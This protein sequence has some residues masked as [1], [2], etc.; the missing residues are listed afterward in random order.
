M[1][2]DRLLREVE[3]RL[4]DQPESLRLEILDAL[5]EE[6]GRERRHYPVESSVEIER[7][8][9]AEA[10][11]LR[12]VLEAINRQARLEETIDEVLKQLRRLVVYDSCSVALVG[13]GEGFRIIAV[14][15]FAEPEQ[16]IGRR[17]DSLLSR[18]MRAWPRPIS[19]ADV[20]EDPRCADVPGTG[21]IRS[22]A[23][24][25]LLVEGEIIGMLTLDR[26]TVNP[27]DEEDVHRAKAVAFSAAAAIRKAQLHEQLKRYASLMERVVA[28]DHA[29]FTGRPAADV[30]RVILE[31]ALRIGSHR[32][33]LLIIK[34]AGVDTV[35]AATGPFAPLQ[36]QAPP[37]AFIVAGATR[38]SASQ[39]AKLGRS[40]DLT[41]PDYGMYVVPLMVPDAVVGSLALLDPDGETPDDRLME[42]YASRAATA[43]LHATRK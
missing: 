16:M 36:G 37:A 13:P 30:A 29:V 25:P 22:W 7:E 14:R 17:F 38:I 20:R 12:E 15:G 40:L 11:T 21:V 33:G 42:A 39:A 3:K 34:Q 1:N 32:D 41:L 28:I 35:V 5:R 23:G 8:R 31:G 43:Y 27:F 4:G 10:E 6:I 2:V 9:R 26:H 19:V 24:I 18:E